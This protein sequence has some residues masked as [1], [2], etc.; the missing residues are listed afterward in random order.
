MSCERNFCDWIACGQDSIAVNATLQ[1][2]TQYTWFITAGNKAKY[3]GTVE[4]DADGH[5]IITGLPN[6]LLNP[7]AGVFILNV[8]TGC[9]AAVFNDSAYCD[10]FDTISFEVVNGSTDKNTLGCE[11][12][13]VEPTTDCFPTLVEFTDEATKDITYTS[14]MRNKYGDIPTVQVWIYVNGVLTNVSVSVSFDANP[15]TLI[16]ID[17]GGISSG[18]IVIR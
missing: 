5:F 18:V 2:S 8:G 12:L 15:A 1:P 7:Y 14:A 11:C 3:S 9:N 6:G 10:P 13:G 17:F 16:S 4:T